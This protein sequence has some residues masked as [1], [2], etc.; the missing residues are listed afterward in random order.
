MT[1]RKANETGKKLMDWDKRRDRGSK[2]YGEGRGS[3]ST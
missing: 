1:D 3:V 2:G